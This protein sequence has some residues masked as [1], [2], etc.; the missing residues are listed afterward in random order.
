MGALVS[1]LGWTFA[2]EAQAQVIVGS[3]VSESGVPSRGTLVTV[4]GSDS[5]TVGRTVTDSAGRYRLRL[6]TGGT[7]ALRAL[8]VGFLP[9]PPV[10]VAVSNDE[11]VTVPL[12]ATSARVQL[13][14]I[15]VQG[16]PACREPGIRNAPERALWEQ[17]IASLEAIKGAPRENLSATTLLI[18]RVLDGRGRR[19]QQQRLVQRTGLVT[20][21]WRSMPIDSLQRRGFVWIDAADSL[22]YIAPSVDVLL[23]EM[24]VRNHCLTPR[25]GSERGEIGIGFEP[26]AGRGALP[27]IRGVLWLSIESGE[28]R[29]LEFTFT[30]V[31]GVPPLDEQQRAGGS[32]RFTRLR[33]GSVQIADWEI[34]IPTLS[35]RPDSTRAVQVA[36]V[37]VSG[38]RT[39]VLRRNAD[40]LF[41]HPRAS[42]TG[43]VRDAQGQPVAAAAVELLG[44]GQST[45]TDDDGHFALA[46]LLPGSYRVRMQSTPMRALGRDTVLDVDVLDDAAPIDIRLPTRRALAQAFCQTRGVLLNARE[47]GMIAG[48]V[49]G[50]PSS[51]G[52]IARERLRVLM[53]WRDG[54]PNGRENPAPLR[55]VALETDSSG[56]FQLCG[57]PLDAS[58]AVRA[59]AAG[60]RS[61]IVRVNV[62]SDSLL[63][64]VA[65]P[66]F[67]DAP[68]SLVIAGVVR[69]SSQRPLTDV[70]VRVPSTGRATRT[71]TRGAFVLRDIPDGDIE[72]SA[73][74]LGYEPLTVRVRRPFDDSVAIE[75]RLQRVT[76]LD[77]VRSVAPAAPSALAQFEANRRNGI[78]QFF[79]PEELRRAD[80][81]AMN[82]VL[83]QVPGLRVLTGA[84]GRLWIA[85]ARATQ[86]SAPQSRTDR[87]NG[88][89]RACYAKVF[90]DG[91]LVYGGS[92]SEPLFD[93][94]TVRVEELDAIEYYAGGSQVPSQYGGLGASC[95]V[96]VLW[97]RRS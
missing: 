54:V 26:V 5:S 17:A 57:L 65:I 55:T 87:M 31:P 16:T 93:L 24:F 70:D 14:A 3:V 6:P 40:T 69:D 47:R 30:A 81:T 74:K 38:G 9:S 36:S 33:D 91:A 86:G 45:A 94:S 61:P 71:D 58:I 83:G 97:T 21:P 63:S 39:L 68:A 79:T 56:A 72:V 12:R 88:A 32:L 37:S 46:N 29:R 73:R 43:R 75:L 77:A 59:L 53:R 2:R 15:R 67:G 44:A 4:T 76:V 8:R 92:D 62:P 42:L 10:I 85:S 90:Q 96:L 22:T 78:G 20:Q 48:I 18:D 13:A 35:A 25:F 41:Q 1:T 51:A 49:N 84:G 27:D 50:S 34:R 7:F 28:L 66:S 82:A 19:V 89:P 23:S 64:I 80:G 60:H 95:G 52:G 11:T